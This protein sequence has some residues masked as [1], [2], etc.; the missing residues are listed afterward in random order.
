MLED[1]ESQSEFVDDA[2]SCAHVWQSCLEL[3]VHLSP[4]TV[5]P[6][7]SRLHRQLLHHNDTYISEGVFLSFQHMMMTFDR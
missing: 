7:L 6:Q 5:L 1:F 4:F 3:L 2:S